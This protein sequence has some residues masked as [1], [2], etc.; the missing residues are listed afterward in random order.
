MPW[1]FQRP[2]LNS[3]V[4]IINAQSISGRCGPFDLNQVGLSYMG[5]LFAF[6][7]DILFMDLAAL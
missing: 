4:S 3:R 6:I 5:F 1:L 7:G 2:V